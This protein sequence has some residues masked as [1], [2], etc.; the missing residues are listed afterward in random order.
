MTAKA[1][2]SAINRFISGCKADNIY[3][4]LQAACVMAGWDGL[5]G[6]LTPLVGASPTNTGFIDSDYDRG[7]VGLKGDG[8]SKYLD[9]NRAGDADGQNDQ[10]FS[11]YQSATGAGALVGSGAGSSG[12]TNIGT[13][14]AYGVRHR[15]SENYSSASQNATGFAGASRTSASSFTLR[16]PSGEED[17]SIVSQPP[18]TRTY[19]L[20]ARNES[21]PGLEAFC[22]A[23]LSF[24]SI[25]SATDLALLDTRVSQLMADLRAI[26]EDG[27]DADAVA[28]IRN[29]ETADAAYLETSVKTSINR[30]V[31]GLKSDGLWESLKASCLLCGPRTLAGA[32]VPLRGVAPT[33]VA[34]T[35]GDY[36]RSAGLTGDGATTYLDS[37]VAG[38]AH[39]DENHHWSVFPTTGSS[40]NRALFGYV[41]SQL[42]GQPDYSYSF[43]FADASSNM[44]A[45]YLGGT[46]FYSG[47][48]A[49]TGLAGMSTNNDGTF[50]SRVDGI[51]KQSAAISQTPY[52]AN[53]YVFA[54]NNVPG[55]ASRTDATIAFYSI[56][57][58]LD[59]AL[60]DSHVSNYVTAIGASV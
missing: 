37:N 32:L 52:P 16:T 54:R 50:T 39:D 8:S 9:S 19:W 38:D 60:L 44:L 30:L 18:F 23:T 12:A 47:K 11:A 10:H 56:G 24:Y 5:A 13:G 59:L 22:N 41:T 14:V 45:Y 29:V 55:A 49:A 26:E 3:N 1:R 33:A 58:S 43:L 4:D 25:G 31:V 20:F 21:S 40:D 15:S 53:H 35:D 51:N 28:Y 57:T 36:S 27:F 7:G 6:A 2:I 48:G 46:T 17:V 42:A 34:F